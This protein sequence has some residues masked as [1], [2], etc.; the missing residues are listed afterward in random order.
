VSAMRSLRGV[1][2]TI[3]LAAREP[4]HGPQPVGSRP[5]QMFMALEVCSDSD[6]TARKPA[7]ATSADAARLVS[8]SMTERATPALIVSACAWRPSTLKAG[9]QALSSHSGS[10]CLG[11]FACAGLDCNAGAS[12]TTA[13]MRSLTS[14]RE[15]STSS[16]DFCALPLGPC[17][18][19]SSSSSHFVTGMGF[20][21][22]NVSDAARNHAARSEMASSSGSGLAGA[23]VFFASSTGESVS[24][25]SATSIT[26]AITPLEVD[27]RL[28]CSSAE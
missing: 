10:F 19:S 8:C 2:R 7:L 5:F 21:S 14:L 23:G 20:E 12:P 9:D 4:G 11:I 18:A 27:A 25:G 15:A 1:G 26:D 28:S 13:A 17:P 6:V 22:S 16:L 3:C 24:L